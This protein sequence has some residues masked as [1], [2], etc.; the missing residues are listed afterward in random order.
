[1][2]NFVLTGVL[3]ELKIETRS[4]GQKL[5]PYNP[6]YDMDHIQN[7]TSNISSIAMYSL[8]RCFFLPLPSNDRSD[9]YIDRHT[10]IGIELLRASL[11]K[12]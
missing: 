10:M 9:T 7:D 4:S 8:Q 12:T 3:K 2:A 11:N 1:L 6:R 5:K